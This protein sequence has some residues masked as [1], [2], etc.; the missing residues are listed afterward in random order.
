M[1]S[2]LNGPYNDTVQEN[3]G[4][5]ATDDGPI[6]GRDMVM[7]FQVIPP[8]KAIDLQ[9]ALGQFNVTQNPTLGLGEHTSVQ[10]IR[11]TLEAGVEGIEGGQTLNNPFDPSMN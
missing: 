7:E 9:T 2:T 8:L 10:D 11:N 3:L 6:A 5:K 4:F 1:I